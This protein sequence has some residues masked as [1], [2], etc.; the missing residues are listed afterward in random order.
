MRMLPALSENWG[1]KKPEISWCDCSVHMVN[2]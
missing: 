1:R 2:A